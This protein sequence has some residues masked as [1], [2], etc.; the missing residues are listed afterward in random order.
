MHMKQLWTIRAKRRCRYLQKQLKYV[1][2]DHILTIGVFLW[3]VGMYQYAQF[4]KE[5]AQ[6]SLVGWGVVVVLLTS[7]LFVG[8]IAWLTDPADTLFWSVREQEWYS[9]MIRAVIYSMRVPVVVLATVVTMASPLLIKF[10]AL[11]VSDVVARGVILIVLK[12]L[13]FFIQVYDV[14]RKSGKVF[15]S[16]YRFVLYSSVIGIFLVEKNVSVLVFLN[17]GIVL[18]GWLCYKIRIEQKGFNWERMIAYE[19]TRK[20]QVGQWLSYFTPRANTKKT[21]VHR[22]SYLDGM[23]RIWSKQI[24]KTPYG[25]LLLR[26]MMRTQNHGLL[27]IACWGVGIGASFSFSSFVGIVFFQLLIMTFMLIYLH[28]VSRSIRYEAIQLLDEWNGRKR[29]IQKWTTDI[30]AVTSLL[31]MLSNGFAQK[32]SVALLLS[33]VWLGGYALGIPFIYLKWYKP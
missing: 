24:G 2:N 14:T 33:V 9:Y 6:L 4:V 27:F 7:S 3:V 18:I 13:D 29:V 15:H 12:G 30:L 25:Y 19:E 8:R 32:S 28:S 22:R 11:S 1:V 17:G 26:A 20:Q 31:F 21:I 23:I 10:A 16:G 5:T